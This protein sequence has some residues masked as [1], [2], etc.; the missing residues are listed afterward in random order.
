M[1]IDDREFVICRVDGKF[2]TLPNLCPHIGGPLAEGDLRGAV[3]TCP[4]H[5]WQ[6]DVT[7]GRC[8]S[9]DRDVA[10]YPTRV[11]EGWVVA[12]LPD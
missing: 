8:L 5:G 1:A 11:E 2:H 9:H 7:D 6:F 3:L 10:C 4:W 12:E